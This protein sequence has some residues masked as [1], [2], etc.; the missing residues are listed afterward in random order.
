MTM[1]Y[2]TTAHHASNNSRRRVP[3]SRDPHYQ[4]FLYQARNPRDLETTDEWFRRN[5]SARCRI[6]GSSRSGGGFW[7]VT[8][9]PRKGL[10]CEL[11]AEE[12]R[13]I[14]AARFP[15]GTPLARLEQVFD[16]L[17]GG[18]CFHKAA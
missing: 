5:P 4:K 11:L 3:L 9:Y 8:F 1:A 16:W 7:N 18:G 6:V 15:N 12:L 2:T 14:L 13:I 10:G 17:K